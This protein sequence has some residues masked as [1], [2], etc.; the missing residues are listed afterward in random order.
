MNNQIDQ[1]IAQQIMV[2]KARNNARKMM[3][4]PN[5]S[6]KWRLNAAIA[7]DANKGKNWG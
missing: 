7:C 2:R 4:K 3:A 1:A 5:K 6:F